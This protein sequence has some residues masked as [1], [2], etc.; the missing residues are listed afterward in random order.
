M[1]VDQGWVPLGVG[2]SVI[3]MLQVL[4]LDGSFNQNRKWGV[5]ICW[6]VMHSVENQEVFH[7]P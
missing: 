4:Q 6:K 5:G 3:A 7:V 1:A 2:A